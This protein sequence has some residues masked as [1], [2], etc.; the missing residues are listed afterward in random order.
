MDRGTIIKISCIA[1][2][3]VLLIAI[4]VLAGE[5]YDEC[6]REELMEMFRM[7]YSEKVVMF[8]RENLEYA[9]VEVDAVFLGDSLTDGCD[10]S[11][12]YPEIVALNRGIGGDTTH[13]LLDRL[14]QSVFGVNT[15]VVV[16]LIG[17]NNLKT[18]LDDYEDIV[19]TIK[20]R[21]PQSKLIICSLTSMGGEWGRNNALAIANN[22]QIEIIAKKY[23]CQFV[24]LFNP[25]LNK[26]T[27]EIYE[28]YTSDGGHLTPDGYRVI[29]DCIKEVL[30]K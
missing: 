20:E 1:L 28:H 21:M 10:L 11:Y 14:E 8:K 4:C 3:S 27:G 19:K 5:V 17:A 2:I 12:Y 16:L 22:V 26:E 29:T 13:G 9:G 6:K 30:Y 18:M 23:G 25:L 24:D 7:Y 15:K